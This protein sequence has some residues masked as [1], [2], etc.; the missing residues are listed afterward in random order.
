MAQQDTNHTGR[1]YDRQ[2]LAVIYDTYHQPIY[3]YIYRRIGHVDTAR[4]LAADVFRALLEAVQQGRS[5]AISVR[6]WLYRTAHNLVVDEY[7]RQTHRQHLDVTT[8]LLP[9][10]DTA[11]DE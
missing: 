11:A 4:E 10:A 3:E 6:A 7:R 8:L 1:P 2:R 9:V 5:P